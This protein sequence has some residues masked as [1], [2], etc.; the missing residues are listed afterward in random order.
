MPCPAPTGAPEPPARPATPACLHPQP[1]SNAPAAP[2]ERAPHRAPPRACSPTCPHPPTLHLHTPFCSSTPCAHTLPG[3]APAP[4]A[5]APLPCPEHARTYACPHPACSRAL[6]ARPHLMHTAHTFSPARR[7]HAHALLAHLHPVHP[8]PAHTY[9]LL[10]DRTPPARRPTPRVHTCP[11]AP[12]PRTPPA[13]LRPCTPA[14][15]H[16][17]PPRAA[18]PPGPAL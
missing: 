18:P 1:A 2:T 3:P 8:P 16:T 4:R 15:P 17:H 7:A 11:G 5:P 6:R 14:R 12:A 9:A 10:R 13:H